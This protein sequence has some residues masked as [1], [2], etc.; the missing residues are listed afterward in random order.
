MSAAVQRRPVRVGV[1]GTGAVSQIVHMP[2]LTDRPYFP[3]N[4]VRTFRYRHWLLVRSLVQ[5][6][7]KAPFGELF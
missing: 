5:S 1:L 4:R 6:I 3:D 7:K 2:I